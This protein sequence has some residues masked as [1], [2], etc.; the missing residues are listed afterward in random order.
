MSS[1]LV[2]VQIKTSRRLEIIGRN[3]I[4]PIIGNAISDRDL[5][6]AKTPELGRTYLSMKVLKMYKTS[7]KK[8]APNVTLIAIQNTPFFNSIKSSKFIEAALPTRNIV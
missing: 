4:F 3:S 8:H 2:S 1:P 6:F 7:N 5:M